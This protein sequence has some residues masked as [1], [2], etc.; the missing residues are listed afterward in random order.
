MPQKETENSPSGM[1]FDL[2]SSCSGKST[3]YA[4]T[5]LPK[6]KEEVSVELNWVKIEF[7]LADESKSEPKELLAR[8]NRLLKILDVDGKFDKLVRELDDGKET[9]EK[10][11]AFKKW[12]VDIFPKIEQLRRKV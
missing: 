2:K 3:K 11:E 8:L 4:R 9:E 5:K 12:Q 1:V 10:A 6:I 7:E